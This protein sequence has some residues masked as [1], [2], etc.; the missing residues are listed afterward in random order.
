MGFK[1][2]KQIVGWGRSAVLEV[3]AFILCFVMKYYRKRNAAR[4]PA[5]LSRN[6]EYLLEKG[7]DNGVSCQI[8]GTNYGRWL[9]EQGDYRHAM[10]VWE[11]GLEKSSAKLIVFAFMLPAMREKQDYRRMV[12]YFEENLRIWEGSATQGRPATQGI[13]IW[14]LMG[15]EIY[16]ALGNPKRADEMLNMAGQKAPNEHEFW[17]EKENIGKTLEIFWKHRDHF[18]R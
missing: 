9:C 15:Y 12:A 6:C 16:S 5:F 13:W 14:Y 4:L 8:L 7:P 18:P 2:M 10:D 1:S 11:R 3:W 17:Q